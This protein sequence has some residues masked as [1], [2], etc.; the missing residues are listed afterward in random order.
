MSQPT[1]FYQPGATVT[2]SQSA[3]ISSLI[4][5]RSAD[6][7]HIVSTAFAVNNLISARIT[8]EANIATLT[9]SSTNQLTAINSL[10]ASRTVDE[11][12][13][14]T[15]QTAVTALSSSSSGAQETTFTGWFFGPSFGS[16]YTR[17][18]SSL[19]INIR[20]H[21]IGNQVTLTLY[22]GM[23]NGQGGLE[24]I[25]NQQLPAWARPANDTCMPLMIWT[26]NNMSPGFLL[27]SAAGDI[28]MMLISQCWQ[29]NTGMIYD[30]NVTYLV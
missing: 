23:A 19:N 25:Y 17:G 24:A 10:I 13:I 3:S 15:L 21:R 22:K 16:Q 2:G 29:Y 26:Y 14:A 8:D 5:S 1:V 12:S 4:E 18:G 6:E 11:A 7:S 27:L 30:T 9:T 28:T 20:V